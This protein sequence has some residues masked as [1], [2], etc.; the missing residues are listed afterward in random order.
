MKYNIAGKYPMMANW[1]IVE[2]TINGMYYVS[3]VLT[4]EIYEFDSDT[5]HFLCNLNGKRNPHKVAR[6][7][8]VDADELMD[9]FDMNLL[10]RT[11]RRLLVSGGMRLHTLFIPAKNKTKSIVPQLYNWGLCVGWLPMLLYGFYRLLFTSYTL[12]TEYILLG[13]IF[14]IVIG[15]LMHELSH[16]MACLCYGGRFFEAGIMWQKFYP[17]AYVL[18][19]KSG[20]RSRLKKVQIDA[21]GA[22]MNLML[23]GLFLIL[24]TV[25]EVL[26]GFFLYAAIINGILAVFNLAFIDGLDGSSVVG[27]LLGLQDGV[28]GAKRLLKK[29]FH[30]N[31]RVTSENRKI[32]ILTCV[33]ILVYQILLPIVLINNVFSIIGGFL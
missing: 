5:Y 3:N 10:V 14:S 12:N 6:K 15:L 23:T 13:Y 27:E 32:L 17:G 1:L 16:A 28:E 29:E 18:I 25:V 20:I 26:S 22:E 30:G 33:I 7:F 21:A 24:C 11:G 8:G 2:R 31:I 4:D 9:Y 19:D